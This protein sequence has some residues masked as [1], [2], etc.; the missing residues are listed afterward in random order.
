MED[1]MEQTSFILDSKTSLGFRENLVSKIVS[2]AFLS[3]V[4]TRL[5]I[6]RSRHTVTLLQNVLIDF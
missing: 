5:L 2:T 1:E 4:S 6:T 3:S